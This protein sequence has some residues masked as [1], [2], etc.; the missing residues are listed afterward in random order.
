MSV[1]DTYFF[2]FEA[3]TSKVKKGTE[4]GGKA[5]DELTKKLNITEA[6]ADKTGKSFL[7]MAKSAGKALSA[8]VA[9][10]AIKAI[11]ADTADHTFAVA[12]QARAL[13]MSVE[14]LSTWQ[15]AVVSAGGTAE[16]ATASL[17]TLRTKFVEMSRFGV[18]MGPDSFMFKQLGLSAQ[19]MKESIK[20]P[21]VALGKLAETFGTLNRTQQLYIGKKL[22]L[23]QGT[24]AIL[25]QGREKFDQIIAKQKELGVVTEK[26]AEAATRYKLA[27]MELVTVYE[28][29]KREITTE[30]LPAFTWIIE[31]V[32]SLIT[33][34]REHKAFAI[35]FFGGMAAVIAVSLVPALVTA[36]TAMWALLAPLLAIILPIAAVGVAFG[37]LA[38]DIYNFLKGNNSV[39]GELSKKWP[40]V[41][42]VVRGVADDVKEAFGIITQ[43]FTD[44]EAAFKRL[45]ALAEKLFHQIEKFKSKALSWAAKKLGFGSDDV[46]ATSA[47]PKLAAAV[48][49]QNLPIDVVTAAAAAE[50][51]YGVPAKVTMAQWALESNRG[52]NM[53]AGSNN[54][55]GIKARAGQ[56]FIEAMTTEHVNGQDVRVSQ[57]FA[58][59]D[60]LADAFEA[61][62]KLL[63]N[64]SAYSDARKHKD[65]PNAYADALTG[66][67]AT[68]P[69][70]GAKLKSIMGSQDAAL[71][72]ARRQQLDADI[73]L[74]Q[75]AIAATAAPIAS[76]TSQSIANS[77]TS[78]RTSS[79]SVGGVTINTKSTDPKAIRDE[80]HNSLQ[81]QLTNM[82]DQYDD[83]V[84]I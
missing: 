6:I 61:H 7:E 75:S 11:T 29:V 60:S 15:H 42:Q 35:G 47:S 19:D 28:T 59:Y 73:R 69:N 45:I 12:Q 16:G 46:P 32:Q 64:G 23:D 76:Q 79:L 72:A 14:S 53:P 84:A 80:F 33:W 5:A 13:D 1:L 62:A 4:E 21:T 77:R 48:G 70:Y 52:K 3:D 41:G 66:K 36:A 54:P 22:G 17:E 44:P 71:M 25:S 57:K 31:K 37:L 82:L 56:P 55:F 63:A 68:D 81:G 67:Y 34:F 43:A 9:L 38:D 49:A 58:K 78:N 40:I 74:G 10:G 18:M 24:I 26:Q 83:G 27:Q 20:D 50:A 8:V 2:M 65:D 30:L 51:K 39:I